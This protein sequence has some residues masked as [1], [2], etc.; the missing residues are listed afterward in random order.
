LKDK[1]DPHRTFDRLKKI[2]D[3]RSKLVHGGRVKPQDLHVATQD[4]AE[5]SKV[6]IRKAVESGW[7]NGITLDAIALET[8][9]M[10]TE[11]SSGD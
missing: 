3:V 6:V 11:D 8:G 4:A 7:P 10:A 1:L 2:Y 5:L 9:H